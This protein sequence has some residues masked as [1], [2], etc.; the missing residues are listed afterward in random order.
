MNG[1]EHGF[2]NKRST[3]TNL[4]I[5]ERHLAEAVNSRQSMDVISFD[6]S[7]AFDR[8]PHNKLLAVLSNRGVDDK[9]LE[10]IQ[11]FLTG[12]I[13]RVQC[14]GLSTQ[15]AVISGVIQSSCLEPI[16]WS[17]FM[18]SLL[19]EIDIPSVAFVDD[20]KL[21]ASL[22]RHSH[23]IPCK[24]ILI[25]FTRGFNVCECHSQ[26]VNVWSYTLWCQ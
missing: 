3:I 25:V 1:A 10:W 5:T 8:V 24:K 9:A 22:A 4:L 26:S 19:S 11:S 18:D 17:I 13:Q 2:T 16:L 14:E 6:F 23:S 12:R 7:R 20:F 21:L 15:A